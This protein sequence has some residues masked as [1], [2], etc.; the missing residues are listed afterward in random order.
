MWSKSPGPSGPTTVDL[1][2]ARS[3]PRPGG[4]QILCARGLAVVD[5]H[6]RGTSTVDP[7]L[8]CHPAS[9]SVVAVYD[10]C[11]LLPPPP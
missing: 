5:L 1:H 6:T 2:R 11:S 4:A 7:A 8:R 9:S 3:R 10:I